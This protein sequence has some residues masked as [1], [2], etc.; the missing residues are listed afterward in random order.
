MDDYI[1]W[2]FGYAPSRVVYNIDE[3]EIDGLEI[4]LEGKIYGDFFG[5]A[6]F[7]WQETRKAGDVLDSSND[8]TDSLPELPEFKWNLGLKWQRDDGAR[9]SVALRWV[10]DREVPYLGTPGGAPFAGA[11]APDGTPVGRDVTLQTLE[12]IRSF[13]DGGTF[14]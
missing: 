9:A 3:V 4:D 1:R 8:L 5:F 7:T 12:N 10:D 14:W 6:N 13:H 2:I 11:D